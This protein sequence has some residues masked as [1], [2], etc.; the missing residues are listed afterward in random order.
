MLI[1]EAGRPAAMAAAVTQN[2]FKEIMIAE[3]MMLKPAAPLRSVS[4]TKRS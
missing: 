4:V 3:S 1:A 2:I